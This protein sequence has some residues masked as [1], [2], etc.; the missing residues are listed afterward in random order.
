MVN[1]NYLAH[2]GIKG[3]KWG[4]RRFQNSDGSLTNAG[5]KR[6]GYKSTG[7]RSAIARVQNRKVDKG[8]EKWREGSQN[9]ENA[10]DLGKTANQKRMAYELDRSNKQAKAEYK[11]ANKTYKK[12]LNSNTTYRKGQVR[13]EVGSDL[14][15]KYLSEAKK[16]EKKLKSDPNN[17]SL[18]KQYSEL[19]S[20]HDVERAR[21][22][23]APAVGAARSRRIATAKRSATIAI[24]TA[25][26]STAVAAGSKAFTKYVAPKLNYSISSEDVRNFVNKGL[27]FAKYMY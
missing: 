17:R 23:R 11:Q 9:R 14:S 21:A 8:F 26:I 13:G 15:R 2:H 10:I 18:Q 20:K 22:R 1:N 24:K 27:S 12:A 3:M 7:I 19:M 16:V 25:A 5:K 4:I 6:R